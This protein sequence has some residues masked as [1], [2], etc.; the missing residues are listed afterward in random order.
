MIN[1]SGRDAH[2]II[3]LKGHSR[4]AGLDGTSAVGEG[5]KSDKSSAYEILVQRF[6][7]SLG[8]LLLVIPR[9]NTRM[10][11]QFDAKEYLFCRL[12]AQKKSTVLKIAMRS[13]SMI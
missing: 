7:W 1:A 6:H 12:F 8:S 11:E 3:A 10:L 9:Q 4:P 5:A 13:F 2:A